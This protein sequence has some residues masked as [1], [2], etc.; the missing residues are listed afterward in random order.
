M[1]NNYAASGGIKRNRE[2]TNANGKDNEKVKTNARSTVN[3]ALQ[4]N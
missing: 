4:C 3:A 2:K 1:E